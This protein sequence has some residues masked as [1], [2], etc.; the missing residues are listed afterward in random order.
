M[1]P[2]NRAPAKQGTAN[3]RSLASQTSAM[4]PPTTT[5]GAEPV[6]PCKKRQTMIV[7]MFCPTATGIWKML[8]LMKLMNIG[9]LRP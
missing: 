1:G 6:N 9:I 4:T 3:P 7:W 5:T 2:A 8:K